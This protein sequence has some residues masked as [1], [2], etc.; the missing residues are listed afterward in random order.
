M[1]R[2]EWISPERRKHGRP[3]KKLEN[4]IRRAMSEGDLRE[5]YYIIILDIGHRITIKQIF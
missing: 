2:I 1:N 5:D 4:G 3:R